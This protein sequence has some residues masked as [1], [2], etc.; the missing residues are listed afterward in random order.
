MNS[1]IHKKTDMKIKSIL[2]TLSLI[3]M[4][5]CGNSEYDELEFY[6]LGWDYSSGVDYSVGTLK[7]T[8]KELKFI[9][10]KLKGMPFKNI[11]VAKNS[12]HLIALKMYKE[13]QDY[14]E[15]EK[16]V[17][18]TAYKNEK[19]G[20]DTLSL[21]YDNLN[22]VLGPN[23]VLYNK[24]RQHLDELAKTGNYDALI[25]NLHPSIGDNNDLIKNY[26]QNMIYNDS[27]AGKVTRVTLK[28]VESATAHGN[29][30]VLL[31]KGWAHR[32]KNKRQQAEIAISTDL[33][34]QKYH[35]INFK[36]N[37]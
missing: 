22:Q 6:Q 18:R 20:V 24:V 4:L 16:Y 33:N 14:P 27:I 25:N 5:S 37:N 9:E 15:L 17:V 19:N 35:L 13:L 8:G 7:N 11:T 28:S 10:L 26:R 12:N 32:Q 21:E 23:L 29:F 3:L 36:K 30:P 1:L 2:I 34:S 31:F